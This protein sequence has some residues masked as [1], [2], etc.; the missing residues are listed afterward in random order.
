[1][2]VEGQDW[3]VASLAQLLEQTEFH[4]IGSVA[5]PLWPHQEHVVGDCVLGEPGSRLISAR[6]APR[7]HQDDVV[8]RCF[9][10]ADNLDH[11]DN[12]GVVLDQLAPRG[13]VLRLP[14]WATGGIGKNMIDVEDERLHQEAFPIDEAA[15]GMKG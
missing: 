1:V 3:R 5:I 9:Q 10:R 6:F 4:V 11:P 13:P 8:S 14:A 15:E 7:G 12:R 2:I